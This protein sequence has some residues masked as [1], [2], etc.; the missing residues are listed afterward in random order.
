MENLIAKSNIR[1]DVLTCLEL[2]EHVPDPEK[3]I[4]DCIKITENDADLFFSTLRKEHLTIMK[5][6][7]QFLVSTQP[8]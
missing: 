7:N 3:L 1:Y 2:V 5:L 8:R 4:S 6:Y